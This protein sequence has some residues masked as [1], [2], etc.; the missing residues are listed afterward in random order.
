MVTTGF[1]R[2][3]GL[4][5]IL[6]PIPTPH[7][8]N[9]CDKEGQS[10]GRYIA[11]HEE[12]AKDALGKNNYLGTVCLP[13]QIAMYRWITGQGINGVYLPCYGTLLPAQR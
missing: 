13:P 5:F 8:A 4:S 11:Y 12:K 1:I 7:S 9:Y 3:R 6:W 2:S 10:T